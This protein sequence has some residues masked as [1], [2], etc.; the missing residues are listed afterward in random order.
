MF[1]VASSNISAPTIKML[2]INNKIM[3][4]CLSTLYYINDL[5]KEKNKNAGMFDNKSNKSVDKLE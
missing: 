3:K 2:V 5:F 1:S 4:I